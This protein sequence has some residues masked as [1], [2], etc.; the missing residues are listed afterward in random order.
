M[1]LLPLRNPNRPF[2]GRIGLAK[3]VLA[4]EWSKE[5]PVCAVSRRQGGY[6]WAERPRLRPGMVTLPLVPEDASDTTRL[7]ARALEAGREP[8]R[9]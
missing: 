4:Q 5:C 6:S 9:Q 1:P 7:P 3:I 2:A 8:R